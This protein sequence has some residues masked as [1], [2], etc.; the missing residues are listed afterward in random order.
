MCGEKVKNLSLYVSSTLRCDS[1]N[2]I[3]KHIMGYNLFI[4]ACMV[5]ILLKTKN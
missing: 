4:P 1:C 2:G 5:I 3:S